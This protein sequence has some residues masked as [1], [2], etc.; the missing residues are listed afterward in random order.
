MKMQVADVTTFKS[1]LRCITR[2]ADKAHIDLLKTGIR[3]KGVDSH[4][5]CY[6]DVKL[7]RE[8][9]V[10]YEVNKDTY[11]F[12][13]DISRLKYVLA[14]INK[15]TPVFLEFSEGSMTLHLVNHRKSTY[16]I[17][18][19]F[20]DIFDL[21]EPPQ[22]EYPAVIDLPAKDFV[23]VIKEAATIS[24]EIRLSAGYGKLKAI[25]VNSDFTF[26]TEIELGDGISKLK[27]V[28]SYAILDYLRSLSELIAD[29]KKLKLAIGNH[30]PLRLDI[31]YGA[32]GSFSFTISN[33]KLEE[34]ERK[35][36]DGMSIPRISIT[37]FPE[38]IEFLNSAPEGSDPKML[39]L[40]QI[41][42]EG[43]DYSR[44]GTI[45]GLNVRKDNKIFLTMEGRRLASL[46]QQSPEKA[47]KELHI[48]ALRQIP[49][50]KLLIE[51]LSD[52]P[53]S[54]SEI[55]D[56]LSTSLKKENLPEI[57][58]QQMVILLGLATWCGTID[59]KMALYYFGKG[60]SQ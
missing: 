11:S 18:W 8:F 31:S 47:K 4:D 60:L 29:A 58:K 52:R 17:A 21:P 46:L 20:T 15:D 16:R 14:N 39:R 51:H 59:R 49:S 3:I 41:E 35:D 10:N 22:F 6:I 24:H 5:F 43:F 37:K 12:G 1:L 53:L 7:G 56:R 33:R 28:E 44:F 30:I 57:Q 32:K 45:L 42:T 13:L 26:T 55:Y 50:Y 34:K 2:F 38:F 27:P 40:A 54:T 36:V 23:S 48:L 25:A 9:F 19:L